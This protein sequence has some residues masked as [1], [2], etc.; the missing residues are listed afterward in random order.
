MTHMINS[1]TVWIYVDVKFIYNI[2][3]LLLSDAVQ[4]LIVQCSCSANDDN[5]LRRY[6]SLVQCSLR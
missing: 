3:A 2:S 6:L 5:F 4:F 1:H